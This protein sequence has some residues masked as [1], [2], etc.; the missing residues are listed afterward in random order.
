[1][2]GNNARTPDEA[3]IRDLVKLGESGSQQKSQWHSRQPLA[4]YFDVRC[5][6]ADSIK[7]NRGV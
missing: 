6:T 1:M 3:A 2:S 4:G 5:P 7:R